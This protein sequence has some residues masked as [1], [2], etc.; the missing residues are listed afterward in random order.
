MGWRGEEDGAEASSYRMAE[1]DA[2]QRHW[3]V[4]L[5]SKGIPACTQA[6]EPEVSGIRPYCPAVAQ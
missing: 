2:P 6:S 4:L 1:R 3:N 5:S